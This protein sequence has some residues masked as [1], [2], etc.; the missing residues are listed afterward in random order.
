MPIFGA[1]DSTLERISRGRTDLVFD[2]V[3]EGHAATSKSGD[4]S[5]I[6]MCAMYGDV[7]AIRFLL[8]GFMEKDL[9]GRP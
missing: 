7:S 6:S 2:Y 8:A 1:K 9:L 3:G 4:T 5:L